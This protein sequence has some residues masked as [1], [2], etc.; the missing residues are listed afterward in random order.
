[1]KRREQFPISYDG[2]VKKSRTLENKEILR[3]EDYHRELE[4]AARDK[5]K[6]KRQKK[7]TQDVIDFAT[8][9]KI[10][11]TK[12]QLKLF[13]Y[14]E[15]ENELKEQF[16]FTIVDPLNPN[17]RNPLKRTFRDI[18]R[19]VFDNNALDTLIAF[20][21]KNSPEFLP[22]IFYS[23]NNGMYLLL[24]SLLSSINELDL[25]RGMVLRY[26]VV[27]LWMTANPQKKLDSYFQ[28][29]R[30]DPYDADEY[31]MSRKEFQKMHQR[32]YYPISLFP[33]LFVSK[34]TY[35]VCLVTVFFSYFFSFSF[36]PYF[37]HRRFT[38]D[39][40]PYSMKRRSRV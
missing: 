39:D 23:D 15:L 38:L 13:N 34:F 20:N 31:S 5:E 30:V 16:C 24:I 1:M 6:V 36:F 32:F 10:D 18:V 7:G 35:F 25:K 27:V 9:E 12:I 28:N 21:V 29:G 14:A 19:F 17:D 40:L 11:P 2:K 33:E 26:F 3:F 37:S 8:F 22:G 4:V